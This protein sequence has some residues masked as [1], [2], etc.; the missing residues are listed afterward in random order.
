M[1]SQGPKSSKATKPTSTTATQSSAPSS[2]LSSHLAMVELKQKILI[3]LSKLSD[4]DTHQIAIEELETTIQTLQNDAVPM[5]LN[6]LFDSSSSDQ[7]KPSVKKESIRLL[8]AV[9]GSHSDS[10]GTHLVKIIAHIAKRLRDPDS[11]V[12][13]AC[14]ETIGNLSGIYM[15]GENAENGVV[16]LFVRPLFEAMGENN[17]G[18]QVGAAMCLGRV[19][20]CA[21]NPPLSSFQKLCPRVCKYLNSPNFFAKSALLPVVSSLSQVGAITSLNLDPL[22]QSIHDCLASTDWATRKAAAEA[23]IALALHS[24]DLIKVGASSTLTALEACRFDKIKPVRESMT[25]ALHHW[26]NL[27]GKSGDVALDNRKGSNYDNDKQKNMTSDQRKD[28]ASP[29]DSANNATLSD[30]VGKTK[31]GNYSDKAVG[32][33]KKKLP[34]FSD[35]NLNAEFFQKLEKRGAD[36]LPVE[37]VVPRNCLNPSN[38]NGEEAEINTEENEDNTDKTPSNISSRQRDNDGHMRARCVEDG[39]SG[40]DLRPGT[41]GL[42]DRGVNFSKV[43]GQTEASLMNGKGNWLAI[44]RQLLQLERQ[45]G[46]LMNMLQEFMGGSHDSMVTLENRVRGLER[47]VEDMAH[48][49]SISSSRRVGNFRSG[50]D[51]SSN[52]PGRYNGYLDYGGRLPFGDRF[53]ASEGVSPSM[54]GRAAPWRSDHQEPWDFPSYGASKNG[55]PGIRREAGSNSID[56]RSPRSEHENDQVGARRAWDKGT[57]NV[58]LGEGPSARSVWQAS[59]D[60]A[61][62]AAIRVAGDDSGTVRATRVAVRELEAMGCDNNE[63]ERDPVWTSWSNAMDAVQAGDMD[64]A[65][66]EVV[67]TG[68]D[69]LLVKLMDKS[70]PV[71]DQLSNEVAVEVLNAIMP[72]VAEQNLFDLCLSWVQQLLD[73][74]VENGPDIFSIPIEVKRDLLFSLHDASSSIE[75]PEDWEGAI[76]DQLMLQLASA[77]DIDLQQP[78]S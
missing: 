13:E 28:E 1:G 53:S 55:Q 32:I 39:V 26:K 54:R 44:Q 76:P 63:P 27:A 64:T 67:S 31:N 35:K 12:R 15:K 10:T 25:E 14:K 56:G 72:F 18:V 69:S 52:R 50:Y 46:H 47:V 3:S 22:L 38:T 66:A 61:T 11:G 17:K 60:E 16:S 4:R 57:G 77:W 7:S 75:L 37:V 21:V 33:L 74:V 78:G 30:S 23:L 45:Q 41:S 58:R 68:D 34:A 36:D 24:R 42:E 40:K 51:G 2:S 71:F 59:K 9:C 20:D 19:V 65:Y 6:C 49:L 43:D 29:R 8:A 5:L 70:G 48:D 73:L 62:L